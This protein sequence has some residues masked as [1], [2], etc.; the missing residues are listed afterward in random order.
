MPPGHNQVQL[1]K[2]GAQYGTVH[3]ARCRVT[4]IPAAS[5]RQLCLVLDKSLQNDCRVPSMSAGE[6]P[7]PCCCPGQATSRH[8]QGGELRA[9]SIPARWDGEQPSRQR[10]HHRFGKA[11]WSDGEGGKMLFPE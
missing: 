6:P 2:A 4:L 10:R 9:A 1:E 5:Y 11:E 7:A 3:T 8:G